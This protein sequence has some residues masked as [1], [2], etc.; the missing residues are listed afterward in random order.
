MLRYNHSGTAAGES[1]VAEY[2]AP[3]AQ[4]ESALSAADEAPASRPKQP[5]DQKSSGPPDETH[6]LATKARSGPQP[7]SSAPLRAI[8][9][10]P[11]LDGRPSSSIPE[12]SE[13]DAEQAAARYLSFCT[14]RP[15]LEDEVFDSA[16]AAQRDPLDKNELAAVKKDTR[17]L[18]ALLEFSVRTN[19]RLT[20][21]IF[22]PSEAA[23][24]AF[25]D[26]TADRTT[27]RAIT[28]YASLLNRF[29]A[30]LADQLGTAH[31]LHSALT[32]NDRKPW[33]CK[34]F[35]AVAKKYAAKAASAVATAAV[36]KAAADEEARS[37]AELSADDVRVGLSCRALY[38]NGDYY[39]AVVTAINEDGTFQVTWED[40]DT[41]HRQ[42]R[43]LRA[44]AVGP[45][46]TPDPL[47]SEAK[48]LPAYVLE[49]FIFKSDCLIHA[50]REC[51]DNVRLH[52]LALRSS[53][54]PA[55]RAKRS[56]S[57]RSSTKKARKGRAPAPGV[58]A[59]RKK[60]ASDLKTAT[61]LL[62][63]KR[64]ELGGYAATF[65]QFLFMARAST[66]AG[67]LT[68]NPGGIHADVNLSA[69]TGL[70]Y[71]IRFLKGWTYGVTKG[72]GGARLPIQ[73]R[74][75]TA[76]PFET[77]S[78]TGGI[79]NTTLAMTPTGPID[80][81]TIDSPRN[82][83]LRIIGFAHEAK[84]L[85][86]MDYAKMNKF[87]VDIDAANLLESADRASNGKR[88]AVTSHCIRKAA[89]SMALT[90]GVSAENIRHLV[91]WRSQDM[92]WIYT[93]P[94]YIVPPNW[95]S[96]FD[97]MKELPFQNA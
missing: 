11:L 44:A 3:V 54:E 50:I 52:G 97:W 24:Q 75:P 48:A 85:S 55:P 9:L 5:R 23:W 71:V 53:P 29:S 78:A 95:R 65:I 28:D 45:G 8:G 25:A 34:A 30:Q 67:G 62:E 76:V 43:S 17:R 20:L 42:V 12:N 84:L 19:R 89:V 7:A 58:A 26:D 94:N 16:A 82:E 63:A 22:I 10:G 74:G 6:T 60:A 91:Q 35:Q 59:A 72:P 68:H 38:E 4:T 56:M 40:G 93:D 13:L 81:P 46:E 32:A 18:R 2:P 73:Q 49:D 61:A 86:F 57:A 51:E 83:M 1:S 47:D 27:L 37:A 80:R 36:A 90:S 92:T 66:I 33:S 87:F 41:K 79:I 14:N 69:E 77:S 88:H 15:P 21:D 31:P 39:G 64:A 70:E 96:C